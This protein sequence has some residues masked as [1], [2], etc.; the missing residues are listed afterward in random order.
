[1]NLLCLVVDDEINSMGYLIRY[2]QQ[3]PKLNLVKVT[4]EAQEAKSYLESNKIDLLITDIQM[5]HI[6]GFELYELFST[7]CKLIF[8]TG[9]GEKITEA[10]FKN[11][12][13]VL[14]KPFS[15]E[16]FEQ[17][18][19]KAFKIII[20][21]KNAEIDKLENID[22]E[23]L[24]PTQKDIFQLIGENKTS[25]EIAN[26]KFVALKTVENH[27]QNIREKL[28]LTGKHSLTLV[29]VD[30]AKRLK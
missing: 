25:Q 6:T 21:D 8:I 14:P 23:K 2:I 26:I 16:L 30:Y 29:A 5:P 3:I 12:I 10:L 11:A 4:A 20:F 15:F 22:I 9:H 13:A 17:A 7:Q 27:R 18:V 28:K 24:T 1:M 19:E